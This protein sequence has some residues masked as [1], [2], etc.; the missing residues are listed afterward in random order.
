AYLSALALVDDTTY[1]TK[2]LT[3]TGASYSWKSPDGVRT[4]MLSME[5]LRDADEID[6]NRDGARWAHS[7]AWCEQVYGAS[8]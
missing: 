7:L 5:P 4:F 8:V 6:R 2:V 3:G 1:F